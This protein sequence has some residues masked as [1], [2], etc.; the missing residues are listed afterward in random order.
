MR[1]LFDG[2]APVSYGQI[3]LT[4]DEVP[5][6][7]GAFAGQVNGLCGAVQPGSLFLMTGTHTGR[8][9]FTVEVHDVEPPAAAQEWEEV[10]EVS[11]LP[12]SPVAN[13]IPWGGGR[14]ARLPLTPQGQDTGPLPVYRVRYCALGMDEGHDPF[15][16][17]DSDELD[18]DDTSYLD[19]R[20]DRYLVC[21]WPEAGTG[22]G[23]GDGLPR[24][25]A[26]LRQTSGG[27]A[28]WHAWAGTLPAPAESR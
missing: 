13:L 18:E 8:V 11:F 16:G 14:L 22:G 21:L 5:D 15:G 6:M 24:A 20:P 23:P 28:Y 7:E 27:A 3:Y 25:D 17:I 1:V 19:R 26:I 12:A 4:S 9:R 10:V 2:P